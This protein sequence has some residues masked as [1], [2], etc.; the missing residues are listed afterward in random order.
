MRKTADDGFTL[1]EMLVTLLLIALA[2]TALSYSVQANRAG[3]NPRD[4]ARNIAAEA[5]SASMR[6]VS[7]GR[8]AVLHIDM[9]NRAI[10]VDDDPTGVRIPEGYGFSVKAAEA[11]IDDG[12]TGNIEFFPDGSST[13][14]EITVGSNQAN[15]HSV[16]IF[17]LTGEITSGK[18]Q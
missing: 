13:G 3:S 1:I 4:I 16:R 17:W 15:Q 2:G 9:K 5:R 7:T 10:S 11:L 12:N 14:G 18:V 8:S 6:A